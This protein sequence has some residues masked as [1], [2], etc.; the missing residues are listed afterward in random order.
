M[1]GSGNPM[2]TSLAL[3]LLHLLTHL[4]QGWRRQHHLGFVNT[5]GW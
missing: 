2:G 4:P 3:C 1:M 5:W